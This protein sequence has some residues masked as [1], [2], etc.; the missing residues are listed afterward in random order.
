MKNDL[1]Y[2]RQRTLYIEYNAHN[3]MY[4]IQCIKYSAHNIM[5][6]EQ[7]EGGKDRESRKDGEELGTPQRMHD[8]PKEK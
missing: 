1:Q 5:K 7:G 8:L 4:R 6:S 2:K 3:R